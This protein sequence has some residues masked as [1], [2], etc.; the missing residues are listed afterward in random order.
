MKV[1]AMLRFV[2]KR[3]CRSQAWKSCSFFVYILLL[4][5]QF[6]PISVQSW[7]QGYSLKYHGFSKL[8]LRFLRQYRAVGRFP[9]ATRTVNRTLKR[10]SFFVYILPLVP[11]FYP[12]SVQ[13]WIQGYSLKYWIF[14][15]GFEVSSRAV[16]RFPVATRAVNRITF[17]TVTTDLKLCRQNISSFDIYF[18]CFSVFFDVFDDRS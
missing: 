17:V 12:I 6:Y 5:P 8:V 13:S 3:Q 18:M 15:I 7:I 14:Q 4:V 9:V 2:L 1:M 10:C 11:Q 16:G